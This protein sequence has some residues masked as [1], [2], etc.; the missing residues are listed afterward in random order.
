MSEYCGYCGNDRYIV[1]GCCSG[2]ECGCM[3]QP[4]IITNCVKCN[5]HGDLE[6]SKAISDQPY[7]KYLE[8]ILT[9]QTQ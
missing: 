4:T 2:H 1:H 5:P 3:G 7:F 6:P 9:K 8:L